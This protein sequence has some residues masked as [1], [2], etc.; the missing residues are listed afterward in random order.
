MAEKNKSDVFIYIIGIAIIG[1]I[2]FKIIGYILPDQEPEY[3]GTS[4]LQAVMDK[5]GGKDAWNSIE[6][7]SYKKSFQLYREDGSIEIDRKENHIYDFINGIN[8]EVT[9][10][11]R[12]TLY[13][14]HRS[15]SAIYQIKNGVSDTLITSNQ[16]QS[17]LNAATFV[18][19]LPYTLDN[20]SASLTYEGIT[21]FQEMPCHVLKVTFEGSKDIWRHYY[22]EEDL[23]WKGYWVQTSDHYSLIINEKMIEVNG[24]TLSR[25]RKSYRTDASQNPTYLRASYEYEDYQIE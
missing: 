11:E 25:K 24:F 15:D 12:D 5:N 13:E 2:L 7:M 19:G 16:L 22:D 20:P 8:R 1:F 18:V 21:T 23:S 9:W 6:K 10:I 3:T 14:I 4:L 17:K